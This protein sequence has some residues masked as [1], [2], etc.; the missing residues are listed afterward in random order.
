MIGYQAFAELS[1]SHDCDKRGQAAHLA[2]L[3][4]LDHRGPADEHAALYAALIA[5]LDDTSVKVRAALAFGLLH[6]HHAPRPVVL[7]LLQDSAIISRA[8]LQ[9]S[10]VLID[11]DLLPI[12]ARAE[13]SALIAISQRE[14]ISSKLAAALLARNDRGIALRI[15][16]RPEVPI[17]ESDLEKL[18]VTWAEE[19]TVRGLL[20]KRRDLPSTARLI[21]VQK[22]TESLKGC[23][24]VK[25]ALVEDRFNRVF[26]NS[27]DAALAAIGE[28]ECAEGGDTYVGALLSA[29]QINTRLLI[30]AVVTGRVMFFAACLS[31]LT[32]TSRAK[33]FTL[34]QDG[35]RA[36]LDALF[37]RGGLSQA[38]RGLLLRLV[39]LAR[40][41]DL[42]DD[43]AA[44]HY[45]ITTL[46]EEMI[47]QFSGEIPEELQE[48]FCYLNE[49]NIAL[50]RSAARGVM[51]AFARATQKTMG[52][53]APEAGMLQ[54]PAA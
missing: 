49:Q 19:A 32:D 4:Y 40:T 48:T 34:L 5:F 25:G 42:V 11:A 30:H 14:V 22:A 50:A 33:V 47:V 3:A 10:P 28:E 9:Y 24:L 43:D 53:P 52:L 54:L 45:V 20:L 38:S 37:A 13:L 44:R 35:S 8:V 17:A 29:N 31:V 23:R 27:I 18:T 12:V 15:L 46:T 21:L 7:A 36:A 26:R 16:Q 1:Q 41:A 39:M 51:A 6:S 2:A